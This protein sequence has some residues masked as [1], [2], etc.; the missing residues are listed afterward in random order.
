[1]KQQEPFSS[2]DCLQNMPTI[3]QQTRHLYRL[4]FSDDEIF[5]DSY[6][7]YL[8]AHNRNVTIARKGKVVSAL[9]IVPVAIHLSN[10]TTE[11]IPSGYISGACTHPSYRGE[12]LMRT[13]LERAFQRMYKA[14]DAFATLIPANEGLFGY[15]AASGFVHSFNYSVKTIQTSPA[16][17]PECYQIRP[18]PIRERVR[19]SYHP[20]ETAPESLTYTLLECPEYPHY[21]QYIHNRRNYQGYQYCFGNFE[22]L[23][24]IDMELYGGQTWIATTP[25]HV[26]VGHAVCYPRKNQLYIPAI[27]TDTPEIQERMIRCMNSHYAF[28]EIKITT[29]PNGQLEILPLGMARIVNAFSLLSRYAEEHPHLRAEF[30]LVDPLIPENNKTFSLSGTGKVLQSE[31]TA[32]PVTVEQLTQAVLGYHPEELPGEL[33]RFPEGLPYMHLMLN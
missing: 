33:S 6:F 28:P 19:W 4:C 24:E 10:H 26:L 25:D 27:T 3:K 7:R 15:Y 11:G 13:L 16:A 21:A 20:L 31:K 14:G 32:H 17:C 30:T 29:E 2:G 9:Q 5:A 8:Y 1:M 12:G 18:K 22:K 23:V